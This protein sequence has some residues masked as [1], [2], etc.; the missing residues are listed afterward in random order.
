[1]TET[2]GVE[3]GVVLSATE[4]R[5]SAATADWSRWV[6]RGK[7]PSHDPGITIFEQSWPLDFKQLADM[8]ADSVY[9]T[10]EW[11]RLEPRQNHYDEAE[12]DH[13]RNLLAGA[14]QYGLTTWAVLVDGTLPGWFSEDEHGFADSRSRGLLW[15]RHVDW[16]G[17]T[18]GDLVD[19]WIPQREPVHH[20]LRS[21]LWALA[22][23]GRSNPNR[24][25][26][27]IRDTLLAEGEAWRLLAG[28]APVA[29][30]QTV[31]SI[32]GTANDVK[33]ERVARQLRAMS[34]ESWVGALT[35]GVISVPGAIERSA[36]HLRDAF[37]RVIVE[38]R[39]PIMVD[40]SWSISPYPSE[41]VVGPTGLAPWPPASEENL[42]WVADR[43]DGRPI[44]AAGSLADVTD[45]G[46]SRPD[47]VETMMG[48]AK[49]AASTTNVVGWCWS[50]AIDGY[51]WEHG[52]RIRPGLVTADRQPTSAADSF[53]A[54]ARR[55]D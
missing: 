35:T 24:A 41:A 9:L 25:G 11:A 32:V 43:L 54:L 51:H 47:H 23:P 29:T 39:P 46:R 18:F 16:V 6:S 7:A 13:V 44:M 48:I 17:E 12:I 38:L 26:E 52:H 8:G 1:M 20:A 34:T 49:Q 33:A 5:G 31:R 36:P 53:R 37:D 30:Y 2:A 19:G 55:S 42:R 15:P 27:A 50:S 4:L 22:P 40:A 21:Q 45:D 10:I 3:H 28:T 14:K